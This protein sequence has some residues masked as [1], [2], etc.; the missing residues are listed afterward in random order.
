MKTH[1]LLVAALLLAACAT[2]GG[3]GGGESVGARTTW[4]CPGGSSFSVSFTT[5]SARVTAAGHT[6]NLPHAVSGSGARYTNGS[7]QYWEHAGT[8]T[9][10][11]APG[12]P[13]QDCRR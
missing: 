13:Y 3:G 10:T 12:G 2:E 8:A 7:V 1:A 5:S 4:R 6:Y 11:G 9:L